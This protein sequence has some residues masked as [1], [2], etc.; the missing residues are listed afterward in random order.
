MCYNECLT[1]IFRTMK[2]LLF[3]L[4]ASVMMISC[5]V[6][7]ELQACRDECA[8]LEQAETEILDVVKLEHD[9]EMKYSYGLKYNGK[10]G[11]RWRPESVTRVVLSNGDSTVFD[12]STSCEKVEKKPCYRPQLQE[13][14]ITYKPEFVRWTYSPVRKQK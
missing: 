6:S 10:M 13:D 7:P 5:S 4:L 9:M 3:F 14:E 2:N 12:Y 8:R 11:Y 1:K